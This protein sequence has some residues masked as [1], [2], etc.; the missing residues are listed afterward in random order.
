[1]VISIFGLRFSRIAMF[2]V[3]ISI[4]VH[5]HAVSVLYH[6]GKRLSRSMSL[7]LHCCILSAIS[8]CWDSLF[9]ISS[10]ANC[11]VLSPARLNISAIT[12]TWSSQDY[13]TLPLSQPNCC[14]LFPHLVWCL[15][16]FVCWFVL[17][18]VDHLRP[19]L[20]P[21]ILW[22]MYVKTIQ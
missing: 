2:A 11:L 12:I 5:R 4:S 18:H 19:C 6:C 10:H 9:S 21:L 15:T 20:V 14:T 22:A 3:N 7:H 1:M 17:R 8:V 13:I 16:V